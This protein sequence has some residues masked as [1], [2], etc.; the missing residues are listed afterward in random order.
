MVDEI[1]DV[2]PAEPS[3]AANQEVSQTQ[4]ETTPAASPEQ[5]PVVETV[6]AVDDHGVPWRNRAMEAQRKIAELA[7]SLPTMLQEAVSKANAPKEQTYSISQL[8][9][10][11]QEHPEYRPWA[12][13]QKAK[14]LEEKVEARTRQVLLKEREET[15]RKAK[16]F[17]AYSYAES[18]YPEMFTK[19]ALGNKV[20][21]NDSPMVQQVSAIMSD[22]ALKERPDALAIAS[23]IA[24]ARIARQSNL[25]VQEQAKVLESEKRKLERKGMVEGGSNPPIVSTTEY[26]QALEELRNTGNKSAAQRAMKAALGLK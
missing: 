18:T 9:A 21:N 12:E 15:E 2:K 5:K 17:Q 25:K 6:S 14:I 1:K 24:Y 19:D 10:Y 20:W 3:T 7:D 11:A 13:E 16:Q 4:G 22:P 8:E 26:Q 23:D